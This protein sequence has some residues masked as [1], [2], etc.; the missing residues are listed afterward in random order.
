MRYIFI[1]NQDRENS[2]DH[3]NVQIESDSITLPDLLEDFEE[4]LRGAG[5]HFD[6]HLD[7]VNDEIKEGEKE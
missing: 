6:G 1:K 5:F 2:F 3:T 7:I 4:F